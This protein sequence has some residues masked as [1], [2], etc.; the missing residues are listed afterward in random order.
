MAGMLLREI[1]WAWHR[2]A[3]LALAGSALIIACGGSAAT[4][5]ESPAAA[6]GVPFVS[7]SSPAATKG[8]S[9]AADTTP[10]NPRSPTARASVPSLQDTPTA[11]PPKRGRVVIP[12]GEFPLV[13]SSLHSVSLSDILFDTFGGSPRFLPLDRAKEDRILALRDAIVPIL[14]PE[15]GAAGDLSWMKDD[16]LVMGYVSGEDTYAYPI[17]VLNMHEIVNDVINGVPVLITYCPLC[18]SGAVYD[19]ELDG[20][21]LTFGNT[22]ALYQ[23]DLVMYDHQTG[24]YWFQA[25]GE[26]V[27]GELTGS[28]L[29]LLPSF[30]MAWGEWKRLYPQTQLLTGI[31]GSPTMFSSRRYSRGFGGDYQSRIN[32][33][34]F[35]FPVNEKKLDP[36]LSAGEIVLTVEVGGEVTAFP[37]EIIGDGVVNHQVGAE[38]MAVFIRADG[39]AVGAFSRV[40]DGKTLTFEYRQDRQVFVD[41]ETSSIWDA[42]GRATGG[43]MS[44]VQ[45][46]RLNTR[47]S[48]W[49]SIAIALP[50]V[51]V[52]T[53]RQSGF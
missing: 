9:P 24:S 21:L 1:C 36:R 11:T 12:V 23:S 49:F 47:R 25:A 16:S 41:R 6:T 27:V 15:Y 3:G 14:H 8:S 18:F 44:G 50:G 7:T 5:A 20:K 4:P 51:D 35:I 38:P 53:H 46:T 13:D 2:R 26:A 19:R 45:L 40:I 32:D 52:C 43:P 42:A 33:E 39:G 29:N 37:L 17:N 48:F 34:K 28:R 22:S 31:Q 10:L 30:T